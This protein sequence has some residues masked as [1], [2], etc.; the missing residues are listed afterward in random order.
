MSAVAR[1]LRVSSSTF[2]KLAL[3]SVVCYAL[4]IVT[5]GAVRLTGS[6][7]GCL[8][9]PTCSA[10]HLTAA[11]SFH[12]LVEFSNRCVSVAVTLFS[13]VTFLASLWTRPRRRDLVWLSGGLVGGLVGQIVLGGLVVL[14]KLNP[15]LVALHF[16]L[17]I[18]IL[19]DA[20]VLLHLSRSTRTERVALID[21]DLMWLSR[22]LVATLAL[23]ITIGTVVSGSGPHA[24]GKGAKRI[25]IAFR[26]IAEVHSDVALF[27]IGLTLA[28]LFALHHA[29]APEPVQRRARLFLEVL[30]V[31]GVLGYTQYFL[32][33]APGVVE[34][35]LL[36]A[37]S[38]WIAAVSYYL[39]LHRHVPATATA[40]AASPGTRPLVAAEAGSGAAG[41]PA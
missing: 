35:H 8:D 3:G 10:G 20:L 27:L 5:G 17:T 13:A 7:L 14:Y 11:A 28:T 2:E 16:L 15:Y 23:L 12:P 25:A 39:G 21:S 9:W 4:L 38:A 26:D 18:V 24:G 6:G 30:A 22:L 37:T 33:D 34:L 32:H 29:R 31:Q 41:A 19:G 40:T 36:G 1:R